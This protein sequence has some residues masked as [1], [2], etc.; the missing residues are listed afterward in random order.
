MD[1]DSIRMSF[2]TTMLIQIGIVGCKRTLW[3]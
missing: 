1:T 2:S 3:T